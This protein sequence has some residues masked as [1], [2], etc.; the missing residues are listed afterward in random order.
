MDIVR[1]N[2]CIER[3][4]NELKLLKGLVHILN[5][6]DNSFPSLLLF[7]SDTNYYYAEELMNY[8]IEKYFDK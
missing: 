6:I 8:I 5:Q 3:K 2:G 4:E 1:I 7:E